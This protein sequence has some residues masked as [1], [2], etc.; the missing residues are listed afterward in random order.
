MNSRTAETAYGGLRASPTLILWTLGAAAV[1][2]FVAPATVP[3]RSLA[4]DGLLLL[5]PVIALAGTI[6]AGRSLPRGFR[7]PWAIFAAAALLCAG[8]QI[9]GRSAIP[10]AVRLDTLAHI[11]AMTLLAAGI[12]WRLHQRDRET[13]FVIALDA[14]LIVA[15]VTVVTLRW[16]PSAQAL[17]SGEL[18]AGVTRQIGILG[19][20]IATGV[21]FLFASVILFVRERASGSV[22]ASALF[23]STAA[24]GLAAAPYAL[25]HGACCSVQDAASIPFIIGWLSLAYSGVQA[26]TGGP[27]VLSGGLDDA[28]GN[29]MRMVVAPAVAIVMGAVVID[30]VWRGP[31]EEPT[32]AAFGMLGVLLALRVSQ[33]LFATRTLSAERL[34]LAQNRAMI[35]VSQALSGTTRLDETLD[36][37]THWAV[38]LMDARTATIEL[39]TP[40]GQALEVHAM[41]GSSTPPLHHQFPL[42]GSFTGWVVQNGRS[43]ATPDA[44]TDPYIHPTSRPYLG[45]SPVAAAPLRYRD[46]TFGALSC[47]GRYAFTVADL[48]LLGALADQA[49]V[50]IENARLFEQVHQLSMTDPLTGLPN[51]R[52]LERDLTREFAAARRGRQLVAVMFDLNGFKAY[53]DQYG[54]LAGDAALKLFAEVLATGTRAMNMAARYGGDEF[55]A[56]M[57]D[58]DAAG[59]YTFI[60]RVRSRFPGPDAGP[61]RSILG[62]AAG[63]A[64]Y[65]ATMKR[66]EDLLAAADRALY[67]EKARVRTQPG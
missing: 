4:L 3:V 29:R 56:L 64:C 12:G 55:I 51:R 21:A 25:G 27:D 58:S 43:R 15:A 10:D 66:P 46:Q 6:A 52:Q 41:N 14:A 57:A 35:E 2:L 16:S 59:A 45:R 5:A 23:V 40:D 30:T 37:V 49:A 28:G 13:L 47:V 44:H 62:V 65:D 38:R 54:H 60:E 67:E 63:I 9:V 26:A 7:A 22:A 39:L 19:A 32:V 36:L 31:L 11:G 53:N 48:E 42:H 17:I 24:F 18:Q 20:P 8:G 61:M 34:E 33:L 1:G 50:A